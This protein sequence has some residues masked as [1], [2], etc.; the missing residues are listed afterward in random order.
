MKI[1][2]SI[3]DCRGPEDEGAG[4]HNCFLPI[5][6]IR[7]AQQQK[8]SQT[9]ND[10]VEYGWDFCDQQLLPEQIHPYIHFQDIQRLEHQMKI[11]IQL[12]ATMKEGGIPEPHR[13]PRQL[14][15]GNHRQSKQKAEGKN[16]PAN[17]S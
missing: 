1:I 15:I 6:P 14:G 5:R 17:S 11:G 10:K 8:H 16:L 4:Q 7:L 3:R 2:E 12:R 13:F 9:Q